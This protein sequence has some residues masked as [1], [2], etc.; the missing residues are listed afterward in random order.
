[1]R[2]TYTAN[3]P[4]PL[5]ERD[6]YNGLLL[7]WA[8]LAVPTFVSLFFISAP[9]GRHFRRGWGPTLPTRWAWFWMEIVAVLGL[10]LFF[11][12]GNRR[13]PVSWL[14]LVLWEIHYLHRT[15][16]Y[17]F[18][19]RP[20]AGRNSLAIVLMA[21]LFNI[22]NAYLNG[23]WLFTFGPIRDLA[24]LTRPPVL[25]GLALFAF[26]LALNLD[27]DN[28]L[29]A[30]RRESSGYTVVQGGAF[31]WVSSPNYLGEILEWVGF[32]LATASPAAT[33]F[34]LWTVANLAPRAWANHRWNQEHLPGYPAERRALIP[35]LW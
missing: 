34:A 14:W 10:P 31:R 3:R 12:L 8:A 1:M 19:R 15:F 5:M 7:A 24:W 18:R 29:L 6:F 11:L 32:A 9:Y 23:R 30:A 27:S 35:G 20:G 13:D 22:V 2:A 17:P 26:G 21:M 33:V 4:T 25:V 16:V 28:R